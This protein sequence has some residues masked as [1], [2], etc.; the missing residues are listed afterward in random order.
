MEK[1]K[2]RPRANDKPPKLNGTVETLKSLLKIEN[3]R[4]ETAIRI[5]KERNIVFPETTV[6]IHDIY[7]FTIEIERREKP[8]VKKKSMD[9]DDYFERVEI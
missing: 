4:L 3:T 9:L 8:E 1:S 5:E 2:E 6:I 7:K